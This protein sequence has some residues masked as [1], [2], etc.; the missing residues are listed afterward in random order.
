MELASS[1]DLVVK[2]VAPVDTE[3]ADHRKEDAHTDSGAAF[4]LERIEIPDVGPAVSSFEE[5][6]RE[7]G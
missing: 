2:S 5:Q 3:K 1:V 4:D 7:D 6:Q